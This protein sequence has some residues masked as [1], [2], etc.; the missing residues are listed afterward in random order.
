MAEPQ[1]LTHSRLAC[2]RACPRRHQLRFE[3]GIAPE[4][5]SEAVR[6]GT[7][8]HVARDAEAKGEN[9]EAAIAALGTLDPYEMAVV[10]A[11]CITHKE[12]WADEHLEVVTSELPFNLPLRNPR[13][14]AASPIWRLAGVIDRIYRYHGSLVLVDDKTTTEDIGP[15]SN[16]WLRL[17][18]DEQMS[19]YL[20][21]ARE[22]G[23]NIST[24]LYDVTVRP[25]LRPYKKTPD[26][27]LRL[28]NNGEPYANMRLH[29]EPVH[30]YCVRVANAMRAE[31]ERYFARHEIARLD[32]DLEETQRAIWAQQLSIRNAQREGYWWR[33]PSSCVSPYKCA[34]LSICQTYEG[35]EVPSGFKKLNDIHPELSKA[36]EQ[37]QACSAT[38]PG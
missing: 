25:L 31:P 26:D 6:I 33:S 3:Y 23:Y 1:L 36:T 19:I 10:V 2:N 24:I 17:S 8:V 11:M 34:Y 22:L 12:R 37:G 13:T 15:G 18:L 35:G 32:R 27:K 14:G 9:P 20:L 21:A 28:K 30:G 7:A 38:Q 16:Y 5:E 29:D 4:Q